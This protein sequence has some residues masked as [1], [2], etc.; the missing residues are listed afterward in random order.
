MSFHPSIDF[1]EFTII[2]SIGRGCWV[3]DYSERNAKMLN[4]IN[5]I[6]VHNQHSNHSHLQP[7]QKMYATNKN[8]N[9]VEN[10]WSLDTVVINVIVSLLMD[11]M[12]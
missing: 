12:S 10:S 1:I 7:F 5:M 4:H 8:Q 3:E 6:Q 11:P 9:Y 2:L